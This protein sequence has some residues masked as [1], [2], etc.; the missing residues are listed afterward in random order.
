MIAEHPYLA[1]IIVSV[2]FYLVGLFGG[3]LAFA[4][5]AVAKD[6]DESGMQ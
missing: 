5:A 2:V 6:A 4:M 3:F 1:V